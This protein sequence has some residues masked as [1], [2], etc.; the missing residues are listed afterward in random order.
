MNIEKLNQAYE[1]IEML[2]ALG[3][4]VSSE[5][6]NAITEMEHDYLREYVIPQIVKEIEP[7]V[8]HM[9]NRFILEV[10]YSHDDKLNIQVLDNKE[11][12]KNFSQTMQVTKRQRKYIIKVTFPDNR[13]SCNRV[14]WETLMDVIRYAG[15]RKVMGLGIYI[16]GG[17]LVSSELHFNERYRVGQKEVEPG[18]YVCT[19]SST[20]TKYDQIQKINKELDLGL[21]IEKEML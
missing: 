4:P 13:V 16:M 1:A 3:L 2:N 7:F 15:A 10:S 5:Q 11:G 12:E 20:D 14:V 9:R 6:M 17:N 19:Y 18:L 8:E 21:I